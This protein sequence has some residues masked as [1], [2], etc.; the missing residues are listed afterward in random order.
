M[1][2]EKNKTELWRIYL[3]GELETLNVD[4]LKEL[5]ELIKTHGAIKKETKV[6]IVEKI[7]EPES[8]FEQEPERKYTGDGDNAELILWAK[9]INAEDYENMFINTDADASCPTDYSD[10]KIGRASCRERV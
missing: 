6:E 10:W 3:N 7:V 5:Q 8:M 9:N 2:N 1:S 4:E